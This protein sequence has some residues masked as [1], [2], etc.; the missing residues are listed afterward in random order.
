M[1]LNL[2]SP[3]HSPAFLHLAPSPTLCKDNFISFIL[4]FKHSPIPSD[5]QPSSFPPHLK[6]MSLSLTSLR[7][8]IDCH[9][10]TF[11]PWVDKLWRFLDLSF[12]PSCFNRESF[13]FPPLILWTSSSFPEYFRNL[14]SFLLPS[15]SPTLVGASY[16]H[17]LAWA[18]LV[19]GEG[20]LSCNPKSF[21]TTYRLNFSGFHSQTSWK[22]SL[23]FFPLMHPYHS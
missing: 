15:L 12:L 17:K 16:Q 5:L 9:I 10:S 7:E 21:L 23:S 1:I 18:S 11:H 3:L 6:L 14:S 2:N 22:S 20:R 13:Q 4:Q 8:K 19:L